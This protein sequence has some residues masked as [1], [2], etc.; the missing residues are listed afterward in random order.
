MVQ[1]A[2]TRSGSWQLR[3]EGVYGRIGH[4]PERDLETVWSF[5]VAA[6]FNVS[7]YVFFPSTLIFLSLFFHLPTLDQEVH[8]EYRDL[9]EL[10]KISSYIP[11]HGREL[12]NPV[13]DRKDE[14]YKWVLH[15]AKRYTEAEGNIK[16]SPLGS[17]AAMG[18][19]L[20]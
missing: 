7:P 9:P 13:Q 20:F 1:G 12:L 11:L 19:Q 15:H 17:T 10:V 2:Q 8:Y 6:E 14:A 5:D 4:T 16:V 3:V 18:N